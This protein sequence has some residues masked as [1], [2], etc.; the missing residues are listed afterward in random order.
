MRLA[1]RDRVLLLL[2]ISAGAD[3]MW[4]GSMIMSGN[5][6]ML[7]GTVKLGCRGVQLMPEAPQAQVCKIRLPG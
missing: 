1:G 6:S 5:M 3:C 7:R 4:R 2:G